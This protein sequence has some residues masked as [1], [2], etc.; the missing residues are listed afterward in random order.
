MVALLN[1]SVVQSLVGSAIGSHFSH[2]WGGTVKVGSVHINPFTH[3]TLHNVQLISPE[4]DT[5][6]S[7]ER[8]ACRFNGLPVADGGIK[9]R[10]VL[11]RNTTF[12][13]TAWDR[14]ICFKYIIDYYRERSHKKEKKKRK[15]RS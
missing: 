8:I 3:L 12:H 1:Y 2:E 10:S 14:D 7:A 11:I 13:L 9:M 6:L 5:I 4:N 15:R